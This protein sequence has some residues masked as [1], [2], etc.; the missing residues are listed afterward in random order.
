MK[1][2]HFLDRRYFE[3]AIALVTALPS[4]RHHFVP[5][6][7]RRTH[8]YVQGASSVQLRLGRTF[9]GRAD[10]LEIPCKLA[11]SGT[12]GNFRERLHNT[13]ADVLVRIRAFVAH[14]STGS[15]G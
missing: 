1:V 3:I 8:R 6:R 13:C 11:P 9:A 2:G 15:Y 7:K 5:V 14:R 4:A 10:P 12:V